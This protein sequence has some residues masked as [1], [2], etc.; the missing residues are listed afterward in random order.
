MHAIEETIKETCKKL[1]NEGEINRILAW[2][3]GL[4]DYEAAPA[5]PEPGKHLPSGLQ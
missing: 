4:F 3:K 5:V 1:W 2:E